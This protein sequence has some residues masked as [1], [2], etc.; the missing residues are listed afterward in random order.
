MRLL[1]ALGLLLVTGSLITGCAGGASVKEPAAGIAAFDEVQGKE[2][3]LTGI[4]TGE[5]SIISNDNGNDYTMT[6]NEEQIGGRA[7]P[8][9]YFAPYE[10]GEDQDITISPIAGTLMFSLAE[11]EG[12]TESEYYAYLAQ[13]YRWELIDGALEFFTITEDGQ[14]AVMVFMEKQE[15][16]QG[17]DKLD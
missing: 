9:R 17:A 5:G 4:Q 8:N 16:L 13:V 15:N 2:W 14:D 1:K 7:A 3:V 10:L 11:P 12:L 6:I